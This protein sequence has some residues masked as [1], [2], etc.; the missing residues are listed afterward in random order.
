MCGVG[1]VGGGS[2]RQSYNEADIVKHR[3]HLKVGIRRI[4]G[5]LTA[6]RTLKLFN[7]HRLHKTHLDRHHCCIF[8]IKKTAC[9]RHYQTNSASD[10]GMD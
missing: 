4:G 6:S 10:V 5:Y 7:D 8:M 3:H 2:V 9:N 1:T